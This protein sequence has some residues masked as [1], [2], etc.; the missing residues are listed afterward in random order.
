MFQLT[1]SKLN[2]E[3]TFLKSPWWLDFFFRLSVMMIFLR[4]TKIFYITDNETR[5]S[6]LNDATFEER[7]AC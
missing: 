6:N 1:V 3:D 4:T 5:Q 7:H 2:N